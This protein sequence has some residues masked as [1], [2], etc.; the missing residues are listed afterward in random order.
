M[1]RKHKFISAV[2]ILAPGDKRILTIAQRFREEDL[3]EFPGG[4]ALELVVMLRGIGGGLPGARIHRE[5]PRRTK[6]V[7]HRGIISLSA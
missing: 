3:P 5:P 4:A 6:V 1:K 2:R 7:K